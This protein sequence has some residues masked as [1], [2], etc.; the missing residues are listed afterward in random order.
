MQGYLDPEYYMTNQLTEKSDVF[1]FG[2][3]MLEMVTA[4][5]PI[6]QGKYIVREIKTAMD[7]TK[8]LCNLHEIMDPVLL[9]S[10]TT[11]VGLEMFV[12]LA[13]KCAN[14]A[15]NNRPAMGEVVKE[16]E[17]IIKLAGV[18]PNAESATQSESYEG[19]QLRH[20]YTDDSLSHYSRVVQVSTA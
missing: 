10:A 1:S 13:L 19:G 15:G 16:I 7:K 14:E 4:K 11:L 5:T 17:E 2:V 6:Q 20:P 8:D 12:D 18:N 9:Q 3:V